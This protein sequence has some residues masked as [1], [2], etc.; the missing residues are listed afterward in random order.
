MDII[1]YGTVLYDRSH[2]DFNNDLKTLT[3]QCTRS[4]DEKCTV[5]GRNFDY[6]IAVQSTKFVCNLIT[7]MFVILRMAL[8]PCW[9]DWLARTSQFQ[10]TVAGPCKICVNF[11]ATL[12]PRI[13]H[14]YRMN[15]AYCKDMHSRRF[16]LNKKSLWPPYQIIIW[17]FLEIFG[18]SFCI[19][20]HIK[21]YM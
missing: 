6:C 16:T 3:L 9:S 19:I 18:H 10:T 7:I 8:D 21:C 13:V 17:I 5:R 15:T 12:S 20:L 2:L 4:L 1:Q 11:T 14:V